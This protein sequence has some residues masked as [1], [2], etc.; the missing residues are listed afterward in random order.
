M[1]SGVAL[2]LFDSIEQTRKDIE[3]DK[4]DSTQPNKAKLR[5]K[6]KRKR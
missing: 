1:L 5:R 2:P 3:G 4:P 6:G